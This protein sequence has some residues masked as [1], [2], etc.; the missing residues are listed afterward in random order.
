MG[1]RAFEVKV[2]SKIMV[3]TGHLAELV[4]LQFD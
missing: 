3:K 1:V 4:H 2:N